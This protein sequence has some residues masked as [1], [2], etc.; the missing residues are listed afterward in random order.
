MTWAEYIFTYLI[1]SWF[2]TIRS[3]FRIWSDLMRGDYSD[4]ALMWYDDPYE[5]CYEWFW[6][7]LCFDDTL[8]KKFLEYLHKLS[9]EVELGE[10]KTYTL[11]EVLKWSDEVLEGVDL[12]EELEDDGD[13]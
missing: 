10:V 8:D 13:V 7:S 9:E 6:E 5:E 11:D 12:D 3:N 4:Y 2:Q 1:P